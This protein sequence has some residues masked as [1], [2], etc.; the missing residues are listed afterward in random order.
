MSDG[1]TAKSRSCPMTK[2]DFEERIRLLK[3]EIKISRDNIEKANRE[4]FNKLEEIIDGEI[5]KRD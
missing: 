4:E 3:L 5:R 2:L 1:M